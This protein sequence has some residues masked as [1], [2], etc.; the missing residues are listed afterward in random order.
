MKEGG[1]LPVEEADLPSTPP[2]TGPGTRGLTGE[3]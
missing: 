1:R 2:P 3:G